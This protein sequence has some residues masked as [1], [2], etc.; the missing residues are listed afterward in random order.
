MLA[1]PHTEHCINH[2]PCYMLLYKVDYRDHYGHSRREW[3]YGPEIWHGS[4]VSKA[5]VQG[6]QS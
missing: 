5:G 6:R 3:K 4:A 2:T 1:P